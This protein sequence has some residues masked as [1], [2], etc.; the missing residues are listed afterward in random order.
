MKK[1]ILIIGL[2]L[3]AVGVGAESRWVLVEGSQ[4]SYQTLIDANTIKRTQN[5]TSAWIKHVRPNRSYTVIYTTYN[6][7]AESSSATHFTDYDPDGNALKWG[8]SAY[9][10]RFIPPDSVDSVVFELFCSSSKN[11]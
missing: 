4:N 2:W 5:Q 1:S 6:C 8:S 9:T 3:C 10:A 7:T 11:Q